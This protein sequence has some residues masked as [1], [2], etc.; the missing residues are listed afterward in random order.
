MS[1]Y[2]T[3]GTEIFAVYD[4][5]RT[6]LKQAYDI[7]QYPLL[8]TGGEFGVEWD[9]SA[10][11]P[12]LTRTLDAAG[13]SDPVPATSLAESGSSPFDNIMPWAGMR[14]CNIINGEVAYWQGDPQFSETDYDTMVYI[15]EFWYKAEKNTDT[16]KWNWSISPTERE[17]YEKHPGSNRYVGR[18]HVSGTSSDI[19]SVSGLSPLVK[20]KKSVFMNA[21][22]SKGE[23]FWMIDYATLTAVQLLYLVEFA[24]FDGQLM[25]GYGNNT[26]AIFETGKTTGS[27]YH[28]IKSNS[29]S[30]AYRWIENIFSNV[31]SYVDGIMTSSYSFYIGLDNQLF[32]ATQTTGLSASGIKCSSGGY[33][34]S[35]GLTSK[36]PFAFLPNNTGGSYTNYLTDCIWIG[37]GTRNL[38]Y[39]GGINKTY[40]DGY[41]MFCLS[42]EAALD[43]EGNV[44][45]T[46]FIYIP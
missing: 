13:F 45:S 42:F 43:S 27:A 10:S 37:S 23:K 15:P 12:V 26:G 11:S 8:K 19:H 4:I 7:E 17:G 5:D 21:C 40:L 16:Q 29:N 31:Y 22:R 18:F 38:I 6:N 35:L 20:T 41:G 14:M 9:Y 2:T 34:T 3:A 25:L 24:S 33:Q 46:R 39:G 36:F 30:N 44:T 1:V 28:T 32:S